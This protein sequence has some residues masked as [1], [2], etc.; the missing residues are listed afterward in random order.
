[1][2]RQ[3]EIVRDHECRVEFAGVCQIV[4]AI[5]NLRLGSEVD[6]AVGLCSDQACTSDA[7]ARRSASGIEC[8][9]RPLR[10]EPDR[11]QD[12]VA[13]YETDAADDLALPLMRNQVKDGK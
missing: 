3:T 7:I 5:A 12:P 2:R 8:K 9:A 1:M 13:V 6:S 4:E 11:L 10:R